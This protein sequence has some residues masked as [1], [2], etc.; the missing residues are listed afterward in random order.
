[1]HQR[2]IERGG[3]NK[4]V[5]VCATNVTCLD[6][7]AT[8]LGTGSGNTAALVVQMF[9]ELAD[10]DVKLD[11][12]GLGE[13]GYSIT[14]KMWILHWCRLTVNEWMTTMCGCC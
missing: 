3:R 6:S 2:C 9:A 12:N 7:A 10:E 5:H 1:M 8:I 14:Y 11:G 13:E 4:R